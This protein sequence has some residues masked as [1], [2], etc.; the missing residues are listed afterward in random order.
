ML[1]LSA[2]TTG[3]IG[4]AEGM[5]A[6]LALR[7]VGGVASAF[8]IV[9]SSYLILNRLAA[10]GHGAL[11]SIH[12]AGV[13]TG[14][15]ATAVLVWA[16]S[17]IGLGWREMWMGGGLLAGA[18]VAAVLV[19]VPDAPET[20]VAGA[21]RAGRSDPRLLALT[22]AYGLFGFGYVITATFIVSIVRGAPEIRALEPVVWLLFGLAAIPSVPAWI[23]IGRR[24]GLAQAFAVACLVEAVGVAASVVSSGAV[25]L[26][27]GAALLGGTFMGLTALGF[28]AARNLPGVDARRALAQLTAAF[29]LGQIAG[30]LVAGYGYDL[31]GSF[32]LPSMIAAAGLCLAF[33][34]TIRMRAG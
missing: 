17:W 20:P 11:T 18:A 16:L 1:G 29:G 34:L 27:I 3:G 23:A 9:F 33:V 4:I 13:G 10:S 21:G 6:F 5:P 28:G 32:F 22:V 31:T 30:P 8:V 25:A 14:I 12:M 26:V 15:A 24:I 2:V 7:F 19:L